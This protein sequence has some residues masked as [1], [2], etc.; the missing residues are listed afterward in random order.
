MKDAPALLSAVEGVV[1]P[2]L[3]ISTLAATDPQTLLSLWQRLG[4]LENE[5]GLCRPPCRLGQMA[6]LAIAFLIAGGIG[7][8]WINSGSFTSIMQLTMAHPTLILVL[9]VPFLALG[10]MHLYSRLSRS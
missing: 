6:M 3:T 2:W 9:A 10:S 8:A 4:E 7:L 1:A 5:L